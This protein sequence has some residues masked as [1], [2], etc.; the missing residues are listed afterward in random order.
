[1]SFRIPDDH[2][3]IDEI[4]SHE[5]VKDC[6]E[7]VTS[8]Y[9]K[10]IHDIVPQK[11]LDENKKANI[12]TIYSAMHGVGHNYVVEAFKNANLKVSFF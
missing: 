9:M 10:Y 7:E 12:D 4:R 5:L 6:Q 1:M 8:K 11:V 2:W 3:N